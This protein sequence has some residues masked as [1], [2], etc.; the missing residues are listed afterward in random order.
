MS[1]DEVLQDLSR[2][3]DSAWAKKALA[4]FRISLAREKRSRTPASTSARLIQFSSVCGTQ[5]MLLH[6]ADCAFTDFGEKL[7]D[8]FIASSS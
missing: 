6:Q 8:L 5:P 1:V 4:R 3:L 2:R 7:L